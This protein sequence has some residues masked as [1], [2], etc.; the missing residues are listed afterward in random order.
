MVGAAGE[1]NPGSH[2]EVSHGH[3]EVPCFSHSSRGGRANVAFRF[4]QWGFSSSRA[5]QAALVS[6][7][8]LFLHCA[9]PPFDRAG[10]KGPPSGAAEPL[11]CA[12][13]RVQVPTTPRAARGNFGF[14]ILG[15][16]GHS[17]EVPIGA[18]SIYLYIYKSIYMCIHIYRERK[19]REKKRERKRRE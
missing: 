2:G 11:D 7:A 14:W 5:P 6:D 19:A 18:V 10:C 15:A 9:V 17:Q 13:G 12:R 8:L 16:L 3:G 1:K 4:Y